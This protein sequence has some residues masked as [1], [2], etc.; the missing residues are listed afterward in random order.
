[1]GVISGKQVQAW[2]RDPRR[3]SA[4]KIGI[5]PNEGVQTF[6]PPGSL[7]PGNDWIL[8]LDDLAKEFSAP[9]AH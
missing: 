1:M 3:G 7:M 5:F 4:R 2:W 9:G 6:T 8:V